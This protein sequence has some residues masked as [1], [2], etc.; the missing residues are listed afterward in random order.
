MSGRDGPGTPPNTRSATHGDSHGPQGERWEWPPARIAEL[1]NPSGSRPST[2][3]AI[4]ACVIVIL[5]WG[6]IRLL[7]VRDMILPLSYTVPLLISVWTRDRRILWS[8]AAVFMLFAMVKTFWIVPSPTY[9]PTQAWAVYLAQFVSILVAASI[10]DAVIRFRSG[11]ERSHRSLTETNAELEAALEDLAARDAEISRQN[12]ELRAQGEELA[13]QNEELRA[14][15]EELEQQSSELAGQAEELQRSNEELVRREDVLQALVSAQHALTNEEDVLAGLCRHGLEMLGTQ[16]TGAAIVEARGETLH[17]HAQVGMHPDGCAAGRRPLTQSLTRVVMEKRQAASL[18]DIALRPDL[19]FPSSEDGRSFGSVLA[20]PLDAANKTIGAVEFYSLQSGPWT[21]D[22]VRLARWV[23]A[24]CAS[25]LQMTRL[26]DEARTSEARFETLADVIPQLAWI[27]GPDGSIQWYN[28]RW[29]EYTGFEREQSSAGDW[30]RAHDPAILPEAQ[31]RWQASIASGRPFEMMYPLRRVD[32]VYRLFL[33]RAHPL[34][35]S[36]GRVQQWFGTATDVE[37]L[38]R[39]QEELR[40]S[41]ER[42]RSAFA[43]AAIGFATAG[44]DGRILD[45]NAACCAIFGQSL[46]ELRGRTLPELIHPQDRAA[47]AQLL[48]KLVSGDLPGFV[49]EDRCPRETGDPVWVRRSVSV[50]RDAAGA[51]R[52]IFSLLEDVTEQK[53]LEQQRDLLLA[54]E[55]SARTAMERALQAKDEF[56]SVVNHELRSPLASVLGWAG[57]LREP[58]LSPEDHAEAVAAIG[59]GAE[60]LR[61]LIDDL[62]DVSRASAGKL[63]LDPVRFDLAALA[64]EA[65]ADYRRSAEEV[66]VRMVAELPYEPLYMVGDVGRIRQ[67]ID[68]LLSNAIKFTRRG[69]EVCLHVSSSSDQA[70][71]RVSDNGIGI[72]LDVLPRLFERFQQADG[73]MARRYQ[74]LGLGLAL[75]RQLAEMHGGTVRAESAGRGRGATFFVE[76]PRKGIWDLSDDTVGSGRSDLKGIRV[77]VV[78]DDPAAVG[79]TSRL[80]EEDGA[81][82]HRSASARDALTRLQ[83]EESYDVLISDISMPDMDGYTFLTTVRSLDRSR[84]R[85]IP[86]LAVTAFGR[87]ED[88]QRSLSAGFA[89]HLSKPVDPVALC[90]AVRRLAR[91]EPAEAEPN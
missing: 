19:L 29:Y 68:N 89:E 57:L 77:L 66:G 81:E 12:K 2:P 20:V 67:V 73:S 60:H 11:L 74:G 5:I 41:G 70:T 59:R 64:A 39:A 35:D 1:A 54:S 23:A 36:L 80:L 51:P 45:A 22:Q 76:L 79:L 40:T 16:A 71:I 14:Q 87:R 52:W 26:R 65:A 17:V 50:V 91:P 3:R 78:D 61:L 49:I 58:G 13:E 8:M 9:T 86:A 53:A 37:D 46:D 38:K 88:E 30:Q 10:L 69:G 27:A 21:E 33:A 42:F 62:L 28:R 4:A 44:P 84:T 34:F 55:R 72:D 75:V 85:S 63:K 6:I 43:N 47:G 31:E 90:A 82:V 56:L 83:S 15:G 25:A 7:I 32:G 18:D 48:E 24:Q